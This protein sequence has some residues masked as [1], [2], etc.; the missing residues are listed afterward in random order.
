M[1]RKYT[2]RVFDLINDGVISYRD[3]AEMA[4]RWMS[5]DDVEEMLRTNDILPE[6]D[7]E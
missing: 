5:E 1:V 2:N 7:D 4:L 6:E 3:V